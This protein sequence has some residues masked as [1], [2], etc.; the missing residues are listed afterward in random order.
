MDATVAAFEAFPK[1]ARLY[2]DCTITEKIDGT[3]ACVIV[4]ADG[5][6]AAQSRTRLITPADDNFGFAAWVATNKAELL[7]LGPGHHYG[8]WWGAGIQRKYGQTQRRFSLF[9]AARWGDGRP[10]CCDVVPTLYRGLFCG[11]AVAGTLFALGVRGSAAAPGF[12]RP[13]GIVVWH[14]AARQLFKVT[15][16]NDESPKG[17]RP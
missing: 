15:C 14:E 6:V 2:R 8:E 12:M 7:K 10:A 11:E 1:L 4:T 16:E 17:V 13:E 3:N 9:N 5:E